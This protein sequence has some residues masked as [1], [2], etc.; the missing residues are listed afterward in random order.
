MAEK[1][2]KTKVYLQYQMLNQQLK[3]IQQKMQEIANQANEIQITKQAVEEIP[4]VGKGTE[5]LAPF[6][7]GIF[8]KAELKDNK[9]FHINVGSKVV[10]T[11]SVG[12][13][14]KLLEEQEKELERAQE[15]L[16]GQWQTCVIQLQSIHDKMH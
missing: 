4:N 3:E 8:V 9:E 10:V 7:P 6:A 1:D 14:V 13:T 16:A 12:E 2:E 5:I 11:K 15:Q